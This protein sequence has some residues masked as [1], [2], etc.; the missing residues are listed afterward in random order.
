MPTGIGSG[1]AGQVFM[2]PHTP[3][4]YACST[5]Y[6]AQFDG[7]TEYGYVSGAP[8]LGTAGTG[9]WTIT[10]FLKTPDA[11]GGGTNQRLFTKQGGNSTWALYLHIGGYVQWISTTV[12]PG[13]TSWN[14]GFNS[15]I[16]PN[17]TWTFISY[18]VDRAGLAKFTANAD[19]AT[20]NTKNV[21]A[22]N[23]TFDT[24]G[25][26]YLCRTTA[27]Q[28]FEGN[29][30]HIAFWN[31][32][33]NITQLLELYNNTEGKCYASDFTFSGNLV[34]Y[35]PCFNPSGAFTNPLTD[36]GGALNMPL[37]GMDATNVSTDYPPT[38]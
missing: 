5:G 17:N 18:S 11:T 32:D 3:G 15:Y 28:Y 33:L 20:L 26:T 4:G 16:V 23:I 36:L 10:F 2:E 9:N 30:C 37:F 22:N 12:N 35:Y 31:S 14:D 21:A 7:S 8:L 1:I 6:S 19:I 38:L 34:N 25:S 13:E 24:T 29:M 27:G